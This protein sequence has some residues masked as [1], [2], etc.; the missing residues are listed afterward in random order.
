MNIKSLFK[1]SELETPGPQEY[2][3]PQ[4]PNNKR[5]GET[6]HNWGLRICAITEG[7]NLVL[8]PFLHNV[9]LYIHREQIENEALQAAQHRNVQTQIEQE[10]NNIGVKNEQ[11][12]AC[13]QKQEEKKGKIA[14]LKAEKKE[15]KNKAYE[16]NKAAKMKFTLGLVILLPLTFYLFL[17]YSSTF[18]SAFF[19]DFGS[20]ANVL[21][22]MF[23][24]D[25]LSNAMAAGVTELGFVLC[26][27][28]IFMGVRF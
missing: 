21:N 17:F 25:A 11:L 16:V 3:Q 22:S 18:Y 20:S 8:K 5:E 28:I 9:Y 19:K 2:I 15:I 4:N 24:A 10:Q 27:P 6:F 26:A 14:D 13:K 1:K 23:D 7:S 12:N